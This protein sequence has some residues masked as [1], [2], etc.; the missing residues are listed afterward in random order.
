[1]ISDTC[2]RFFTECIYLREHLTMRAVEKHLQFHLGTGIEMINRYSVEITGDGPCGLIM[3]SVHPDDA[4][5]RIDIWFDG[6]TARLLIS[7]F[8]IRHVLHLSLITPQ[9]LQLVFEGRQLGALS[10]HTEN[11]KHLECR[12]EN[13]QLFHYDLAV[14]SKA[15]VLSA[16]PRAID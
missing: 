13:G 9:H 6:V 7:G 10:I 5:G 15:P 16:K 4:T 11:Q 12:W 8:G 2:Q 14:H 3:T 1:M